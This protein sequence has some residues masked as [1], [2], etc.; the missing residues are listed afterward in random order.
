MDS[1]VTDIKFKGQYFIE[2]NPSI[3]KPIQGGNFKKKKTLYV[4]AEYQ[5]AQVIQFLNYM[6]ARPRLYAGGEW[7]I[8]EIFA[9]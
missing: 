2:N 9:T 6:I 8:S 5:P 4:L 3:G 7:K 1:L